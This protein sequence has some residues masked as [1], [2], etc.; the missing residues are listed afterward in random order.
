M[1]SWYKIQAGKWLVNRAINKMKKIKKIIL[2]YP[3]CL[4]LFFAGCETDSPMGDDLYPQKVYIVGAKDKIID[5]QVNIGNE[6]D[7]V[8]ISVSV[9]GSRPS[10][11]DV[12]VQILEDSKAVETYNSREISAEAV[13]YRRMLKSIYNYPLDRLT[14]KAGQVY[15]TYPIHI[16]PATM[17]CDSLYMLPL[18]LSTPSAYE[19]N[20]EDSVVLVR[21]SLKNKYSGLYY[22]DGVIKNTTNINDSLVYNMPRNAL[23]TDDGNT[24]RI[25]HYN[26][27]YHSGDQ[28]DY[29]PTYALKVKVKADN[30][31]SF[32]TWDKFELI[33]GGGKYV[34]AFKVYDFWYTYKENGVIWRVEGFL[35]KERKTSEEQRLIDNWIEE[36]RGK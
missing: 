14:I 32:A 33:D 21:L 18:K 3:L 28:Q 31:L 12:V 27:E 10:G 23:A 25:Y 30:T 2:L 17:H 24:V 11:K 13:Q 16:K 6:V 22:M 19:L 1:Q 9:S 4:A 35:Y 34:P 8:T 36:E 5:R 29:R 15:N 20:K 26:N 7:T